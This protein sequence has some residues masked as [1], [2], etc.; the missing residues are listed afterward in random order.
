MFIDVLLQDFCDI[1]GF[2]N[3]ANIHPRAWFRNVYTEATGSI[4]ECSDPNAPMTTPHTECVVV[5][6]DA[7]QEEGAMPIS[8]D[9]NNNVPPS[10]DSGDSVDEA[11][12]VDDGTSAPVVVVVEG[13]GESSATTT[14]LLL[15]AVVAFAVSVALIC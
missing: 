1:V 2:E 11:I 15:L 8:V 13:A 10:V 7:C 5:S 4:G 14:N 9:D 6:S 12:S 3:P